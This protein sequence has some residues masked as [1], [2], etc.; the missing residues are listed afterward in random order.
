MNSKLLLALAIFV[1]SS[2]IAQTNHL[3]VERQMQKATS[4]IEDRIAPTSNPASIATVIGPA[5]YT[6]DF[7]DS[8]LF[9]K[10]QTGGFWVFGTDATIGN[11]FFTA[12]FASPT[13]SNG[14]A[15]I[16]SNGFGQGQN[17]DASITTGPID[18][19]AVTGSVGIVFQQYYAR[20]NDIATVEVSTDN[21]S[22]T[23]VGGNTEI[24]A[25]TSVGGAPTSNPNQKIIII[26]E[27][28]GQTIYVRFHFVGSFTYSWLVDDLSI[29]ELIIPDSDLGINGIENCNI[30]THYSFDQIAETQVDSIGFTIYAENFGLSSQTYTI[31]YDIK[32]AGVSVSTGSTPPLNIASFSRDTI[33]YNTPFVPTALGSYTV[34]V[35]LSPTNAD[36]NPADNVESFVVVLSNNLYSPINTFLTTDVQTLSG[37][38]ST[39]PNPYRIY[40]IGQSFPIYANQDLRQIQFSLSRQAGFSGTQ[41]FLIE[42]YELIPATGRPD[43]VPIFIGD[44]SMTSSHSNTSWQSI[45]IAGGLPLEAGKTYVI[46]F[47]YEDSD[48]RWFFNNVRDGDADRGTWG[49]G[50]FGQGQAINWYTGWGF[51]PAIRMN[52]DQTV[53]ITS[54]QDVSNFT[55]YPNPANTLLNVNVD[56]K[57]ATNVDVNL[58]DINGKVVFSKSISDKIL[59]YQ[60][61]ISLIDFANGVYTLQITTK[62]GIKS[63]KVVIAH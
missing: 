18:L 15:M 13:A 33:S 11:G 53:G 29:N 61:A 46:S 37:P 16:N 8:T 48:R 60:D 38:V 40:K 12:P 56:L 63:E 32:L 23:V 1:T 49:F 58:I 50:P 25:L 17:Q 36:F 24:E 22:F 39:E 20:F 55:V 52:F 14:Y 42:V 57:T 62:N 31:D 41:D 5:I 27:Y 35:T 4:P 54:I 2:T 6:N 30:F 45:D 51:S 19:T 10:T 44:Y 47:G 34:E 59:I 26:N 9:T 21:V 7:S 43:G 3:N 28:A